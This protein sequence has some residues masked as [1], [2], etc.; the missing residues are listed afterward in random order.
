MKFLG[1]LAVSTTFT[2]MNNGERRVI[3]YLRPKVT[4]QDAGVRAHLRF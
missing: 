3:Q 1:G 4:R 2:R